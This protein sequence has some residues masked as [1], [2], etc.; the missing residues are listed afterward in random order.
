MLNTNNNDIRTL[1][2]LRRIPM[3]RV[4]EQIGIS[5]ATITRWFRKSLTTERFEKVM[6]AIEEI[7]GKKEHE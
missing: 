2:K 5:E 6:K 4:A 7:E 1:L 3:W